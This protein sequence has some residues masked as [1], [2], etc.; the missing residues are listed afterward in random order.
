MKITKVNPE[1]TL[2]NKYNKLKKFL[3]FIVVILTANYAL[4]KKLPIEIFKLDN[5]LQ[6]VLIFNNRVP[7]VHHGLWYKAGSADSPYNKTGLAH[8]VEH[9]MF[10]GTIKYPS[11]SFKL[12]INNL[13]GSQEANTSWDRTAYSIT[14]AKEYLEK[15]MELESDRM[16]NLAFNH[17]DVTKELQVILQ[18]RRQEV[19]SKPG[20]LLSEAT[21]AAF[22]WQHPYGRPVIGFRNHM[23]SYTYQDAKL[24]YQTW[25]APNNAIL[26]IAG[27]ISKELVMP[28]IKKYYNGI[29]A[30]NLPN[31]TELREIEPTHNNCTTKIELRDTKFQSPY[32]QSIYTAPNH[33]TAGVK[34]EAALDLL[35]FILGEES[36]GRLR[37]ILVDNQ[38]IAFSAT[39]SY[40]GS[41]IDP[42]NFSILVSPINVIDTAKTEYLVTSEISNLLS[43]GINKTEFETAK[44]QY[45]NYFRFNHDSIISIAQLVGENL[46]HGYT[47]NEIMNITTVLQNISSKEI[48]DAARLVFSQPPKVIAYA[49]PITEN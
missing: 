5:G 22:F 39:A 18:E 37:K 20:R 49:Y 33:T 41:M 11:D 36:L 9:L 14:I 23:E 45:I 32:W 19:E 8:F 15:I 3:V 24:F 17:N 47:I 42:Y 29:P 43:N 44:Q 16:A 27:D 26:V 7:V 6:V 38:K 25:Y 1:R 10:K 30:K 31:K 12:I 4:A 40:S 34:T 48:N 28:L 46:A 35:Q 13:G 21:N 2:Y